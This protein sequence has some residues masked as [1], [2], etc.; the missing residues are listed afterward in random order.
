MV[1]KSLAV[2]QINGLLKLA[3]CPNP[4]AN[5]VTPKQFHLKP[6]TT[7]VKQDATLGKVKS[8]LDTQIVDMATQLYNSA[9]QDYKEAFKDKTGRKAQTEVA[10]AIASTVASHTIGVTAGTGLVATLCLIPGVNIVGIPAVLIAYGGSYAVASLASAGTQAAV[11][12]SVEAACATAKS[13][14]A[15]SV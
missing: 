5:R 13:N 1:L 4:T 6:T 2:H 12:V 14:T 3:K 9:T 10:K 7:P 11:D 15:S 8:G